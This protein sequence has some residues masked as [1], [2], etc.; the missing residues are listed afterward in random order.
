MPTDSTGSHLLF[1]PW[2][3][4]CESG[5]ALWKEARGCPMGQGSR[6][7]IQGGGI[8][9]TSWPR[10]KAICFTELQPGR[11]QLG[12]MFTDPLKHQWRSIQEA[13]KTVYFSRAE[14]LYWLANFQRF[15][16]KIESHWYKVKN[17]FLSQISKITSLP[18]VTAGNS[19]CVIQLT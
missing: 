15:H 11:N 3:N 8:S 5:S 10:S 1:Q 19:S 7:L 17:G 18:F 12:V 16:L 4:F 9:T 6:G 2:R 14:G 13:L